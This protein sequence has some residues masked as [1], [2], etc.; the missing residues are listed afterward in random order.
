[1]KSRN[2]NLLHVHHRIRSL[3][4]HLLITRSQQL[5]QHSRNN[6][7]RKPKLI[8]NPATL[9]LGRVTSLSKLAPVIIDLLLV[10]AV[11]L[12]GDGLGELPF[13]GASVET[14]EGVAAEL[15][16][17]DHDGAGFLAVDFLA[18]FGEVL[19]GDDF[20]VGEDGDV[21]VCCFFC[22][23]VEPEAGGDFVEGRH[24]DW[25]EESSVF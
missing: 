22:L 21:V 10:L 8:R 11:D 15:E 23:A 12:E 16:L 2:V 13:G 3:P 24:D 7:P 17:D 25:Y 9:L 14:D 5:L 4:R 19:G 20:G 6:L 18:C 1:M